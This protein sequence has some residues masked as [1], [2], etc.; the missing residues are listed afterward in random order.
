M[1]DAKKEVE[2]KALIDKAKSGDQQAQKAAATG[3][4]VS[5]TFTEWMMDGIWPNDITPLQCAQMIDYYVIKPTIQVQ[6]QS[7]TALYLNCGNELTVTVPGLGSN[8]NPSFSAK[9]GVAING[10]G[11]GKVT[12]VPKSNKVTLSVSNSGSFISNFN[13]KLIY[14]PDQKKIPKILV[15]P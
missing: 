10:G 5:P 1:S 7:V 11:G 6:S 4:L 3:G 8:Y 14:T 13:S 2:I 15:M 12:I 9:G